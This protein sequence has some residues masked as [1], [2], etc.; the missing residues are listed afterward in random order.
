MKALK[1]MEKIAEWL[2]PPDPSTNLNHA[3]ELH[4]SGTGQWLLDSDKYKLWKATPGSF[5]WLYG[6]PGCGKTII[7]STVVADLQDRKAT[8]QSLLYFY[9]NFTDA[10]KRLTENAVRSLADQLYHTSA[11]TRGVL[12]TLFEACKEQQPSPRRL[13]VAFQDMLNECKEVWIVLDG[14]DEC[15]TRSQYDANGIMP[16]LTNMKKS[17]KNIHLLVTSRPEQDI[18][19]V[20]EE[21]AAPTQIISLQSDLVA[22][23][24]GAYIKTKVDQMNRWR[25]RP[26]IQDLV[27]NTLKAKADGM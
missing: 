1:Q 13:Q 9:F 15:D 16:W 27:K 10:S 20:I 19:F 14:L 18:K 3:R 2:S 5:L 17:S 21:W 8:A 23:D 12:N 25:S 6:I 7:S 4:Q 22:D 26:D 24:I 11:C